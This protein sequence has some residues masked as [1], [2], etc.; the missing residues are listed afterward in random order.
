MGFKHAGLSSNGH[1]R[2]NF[3]I[4]GGPVG[5][6]L[7][8]SGKDRPFP[9][10]CGQ[11]LAGIGKMFPPLRGSIFTTT[12]PREEV[13]MRSDAKAGKMP[14]RRPALIVALSV[15][16]AWAGEGVARQY[17]LY[18]DHRSHRVD[19]LITIVV[20]E[21]SAASDN[22]QTRT[23]TESKGHIDSRKGKGVAKPVP[24]AKADADLESKFKG[25]GKTGRNG[26]MTAMVSARVTAV[27]ANGDLEVEGS[28]E[29]VINDETEL[30]TISGLVRP[31]DIGV[32]NSVRSSRLANA[33]IAY[34]G[35][36]AASGAQSPGVLARFFDWLF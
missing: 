34:S 35:R 8:I 7:P 14:P 26:S 4:G 27:L 11:K 5:A 12:F 36:G 21:Q 9:V 32:D 29:V 24:S 1:T 23:K 31:D 6:D 3:G 33:R 17:S 30:L 18:A 15:A 10:L 25:E 20:D 22:A 2:I 28:K 16:C 19:D 13:P